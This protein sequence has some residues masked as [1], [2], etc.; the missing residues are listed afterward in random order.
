MS[1]IIHHLTLNTGENAPI[2]C[3]ASRNQIALARPLI[4]HGGPIPFFSPYRVDVTRGRNGV[5][6]YIKRDSI[7]ISCN[8]LVWKEGAATYWP[9]IE[10]MC[11][12]LIDRFPGLMSAND[13]PRCPNA[14]PFL[15]TALLPGFGMLSFDEIGGI[16]AF[17]T[18][19]SV[20]L[21]EDVGLG[22]GQ[23]VKGC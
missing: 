6:F 23:P 17:E 11:A 15:A 13:I 19:F 2:S 14:F 16:V 21:L 8:L 10:A 12:S 5:A 1:T 20:A 22:A 4:H 3:A 18:L 9:V 7:P